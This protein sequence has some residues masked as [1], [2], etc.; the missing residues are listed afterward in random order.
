VKNNVTKLGEIVEF[1]VYSFMV[2]CTNATEQLYT[3]DV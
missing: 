2:V 1:A 3:V